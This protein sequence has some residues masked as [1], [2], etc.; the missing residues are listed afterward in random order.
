MAQPKRI[1]TVID[2]A[3][4]LADEVDSL[5]FADPVSHVYNP[6]RYAWSAHRSY[7]MRLNPRGARVVFVGMNPGPWGMVQTGVPFGEVAAV[8]DWMRIRSSIGR[9]SREHPKRP[10]SGFECPRS[11]VSGR[12]LWGLF[13]QEFGSADEFFHE[14]FVVNYCPLVFMEAS[15]RNRTPDKLP[16]GEREPLTAACDRHLVKVLGTLEPEFVIAVGGFA[17]ACLQR[18]LPL[19]PDQPEVVRILHPS[20]ASPAANR[21]WSGTVKRQL[22]EAGVW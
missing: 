20:P 19:L 6:L 1:R 5:S 14:H 4:R 3:S 2:A 15:A 8:R 10:V 17:E 22:C 12:R 16:A 9:P 18:A 21:D 11:E 13:Q 7:L